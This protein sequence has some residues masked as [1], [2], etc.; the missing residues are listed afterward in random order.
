[1]KEN[2]V[3]REN[4]S[5]RLGFLVSCIGSAVGMG[6]IW[7]FPSRVAHYGGAFLLADLFFNLTIGICGLI[8]EM[9]FGR[10]A[11]AG[12]MGAFARAAQARGKKRWRST[13]G[14]LPTV[15]SFLLAVG[16]AV[17]ISWIL[18][19]VALSFQQILAGHSVDM[20]ARLFSKIAAPF[21]NDLF[22]LLSLVLTVLVLGLGV[23]KGIERVNK[24]LI[25]LVF[26]LF[27][28][29][30][31]YVAFLP[32]AEQSYRHLFR[33]RGEVLRDPMMWVYALG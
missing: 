2:T 11:R 17:V 31:I 21:G 32:G 5:S 24:V 8:G 1:M 13:V 33:I 28:L 18:R 26:V 6:N 29:L 16:Y 12:S 9:S 10:K 3:K 14:L 30:A 27:L 19:Y 23:V 20:G 4:W 7:L 15:T 25:P 22:L